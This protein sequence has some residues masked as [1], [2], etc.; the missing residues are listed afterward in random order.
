M[1][2]RGFVPCLAAA[3]ALFVASAGTPAD[4]S[5]IQE[6]ELTLGHVVGTQFPYHTSAEYMRDLLQERTDGAWTMELFHSSALVGEHDHLEALQLRTVDFTWV[7]TVAIADLVPEFQIFNL[8]GVFRSAEH[9][10]AALDTIDMEPFAEAAT[11]RGFKLIGISGPAMRYL[12]NSQRPI[13]RPEDLSG[14]WIRT[15]NAEARVAT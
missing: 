4:A 13:E 5:G 8:P 15:M 2:E 10:K 1:S 6:R 14:L 7:H 3:A 11:D 9:V 12:S